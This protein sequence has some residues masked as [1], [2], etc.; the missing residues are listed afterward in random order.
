[1]EKCDMTHRGLCLN[2]TIENMMWL[3]GGPNWPFL[4][5][6]MLDTSKN[7]DILKLLLPLA[8]LGSPSPVVTQIGIRHECLWFHLVISSNII[9]RSK[10]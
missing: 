3:M 9:V 10:Q 5:A 7:V 2:Y 1:M 6:K 4:D 8:L